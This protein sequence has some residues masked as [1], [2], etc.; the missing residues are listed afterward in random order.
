MVGVTVTGGLA[1]GPAHAASTVTLAD[2]L[3]QVT[4]DA[5]ANDIAVGI[6]P[7]NPGDYKIADSSGI[8]DPLPAGCVRV[9]ATSIRCPAAGVTAVRADMGAGDDQF[10]TSSG[11]VPQETTLNVHGDEGNDTIRGRNGPGRDFL[12][13]GDGDDQLFGEGGNDEIY[14]GRG[15]DEIDGG[16]G[17]D[18]LFGE[19]GNDIVNGGRGKD[20][21]RGGRGKDVINGLSQDDKLFGDAGRDRLSGGSGDDK[22]IG[23]GGED[24]FNGGG[25]QDTG[26]AENLKNVEK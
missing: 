16:D 5:G 14:G 3:L 10:K 17:D 6:D 2:G 26:K 18:K 4:G 13:G 7:S 11:G 1:A 9:N 25:G 12:F 15:N 22:G 8:S 19:D 23:G 20:V 21:M 24:S